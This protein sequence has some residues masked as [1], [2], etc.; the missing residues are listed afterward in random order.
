MKCTVFHY[1]KLHEINDYLREYELVAVS[2]I[3]IE[4]SGHRKT[5]R[6]RKFTMP[7]E[8]TKIDG[9]VMV[10]KDAHGKTHIVTSDSG[11]YNSIFLPVEDVVTFLSTGI[12]K[13]EPW[14]QQ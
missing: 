13:G 3:N 6:V 1:R 10:T 11:G 8:D 12:I 2:D 9:T 7:L 14:P 5:L 4:D